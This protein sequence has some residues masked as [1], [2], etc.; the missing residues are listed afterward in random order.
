MK[1][2]PIETI[3]G[4]GNLFRDLGLPNPELEQLRAVLAANIITVLDE[5]GLSVRQAQAL[6][7]IAAADFSRI[8]NTRLGRF[9]VDRL[10]TVLH[11]LGAPVEVTVTP[12]ARAAAPARPPKVAARPTPKRAALSVEERS[13]ADITAIEAACN[14]EAKRYRSM[15]PEG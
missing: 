11:R 7:G 2:P 4:S 12:G 1:E 13:D 10:M 14:P 9:T 8:R 5:R 3:Q 6:T 15:R